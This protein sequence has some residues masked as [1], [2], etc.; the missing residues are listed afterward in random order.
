MHC[1][2]WIIVI[3]WIF[4]GRY[5]WYNFDAFVSMYFSQCCVYLDIL[6]LFLLLCASIKLPHVMIRTAMMTSSNGNISAL[7]AFCVGNSPVNGEFPTQRP[8][9]R[10]FDV[11][12]GLRPNKRLSKQW[13]RWWFE[14]PTRSLWRHCNDCVVYRVYL[15]DNSILKCSR[16]GWWVVGGGVKCWWIAKPIKL[17]SEFFFHLLAPSFLM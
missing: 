7:L 11:F 8:M 2:G 4:I 3:W 6:W 12:F 10:S 16:E 17:Y 15:I 5:L 9:T 13:R 14:T 1:I